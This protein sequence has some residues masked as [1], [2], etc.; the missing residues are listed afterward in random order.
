[1]AHVPLKTVQAISGFEMSMSQLI[2]SIDVGT[3][4]LKAALVDERGQIVGEVKSISIKIE[5]DALGRAEHDPLKLKNSL[6]EVCRLAIGARGAIRPVSR[7]IWPRAC[8]SAY[9]S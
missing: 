7:S 8:V 1:M 2:L 9:K 4:N 6:L 5:S 3:T